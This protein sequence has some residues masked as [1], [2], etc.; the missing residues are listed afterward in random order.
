[1]RRLRI[2]QKAYG[3]QEGLI[4]TIQEK[5]EGLANSYPSMASVL[6]SDNIE[7]ETKIKLLEKTVGIRR[8]TGFYEGYARLRW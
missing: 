4:N 5:L 3:E 2:I 6:K 7:L 1:M 8:E